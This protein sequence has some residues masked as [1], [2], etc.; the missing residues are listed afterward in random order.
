MKSSN[1]TKWKG[2]YVHR[3]KH[4]SSIKCKWLTRQYAA[5]IDFSTQL[6]SF[7]ITLSSTV[8]NWMSYIYEF[9]FIKIP[10][11]NSPSRCQMDFIQCQNAMLRKTTLHMDIKNYRKSSFCMYIN[12][13]FSPEANSLYRFKFYD[14][15]DCLCN[16]NS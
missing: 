3:S 4:V 1:T 5:S 13:G 15:I 7:L 8:L 14:L 9:I 16:F 10:V 11:V 12:R 6:L 2:K